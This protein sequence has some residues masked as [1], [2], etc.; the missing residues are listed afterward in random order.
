MLRPSL[1]GRSIPGF[2]SSMAWSF[3]EERQDERYPWPQGME[4][5]DG[6]WVYEAPDGRLFGVG[7]VGRG[8]RAAPVLDDVPPRKRRRLQAPGGSLH[9]DRR[10]SRRHAQACPGSSRP[11][12]PGAGSGLIGS[13]SWGGIASGDH[14][15]AVLGAQA[16]DGPRI[17]EPAGV[18]NHLPL[19]DEEHH[20]H[21]AYSMPVCTSEHSCLPWARLM[22]I[23]SRRTAGDAPA[24]ICARTAASDTAI[25][26][27]PGGRAGEP[28]GPQ[29]VTRANGRSTAP[30][31]F[32]IAPEPLAL[33][34][35]LTANQRR[36]TIVANTRGRARA[37][38]PSR[39]PG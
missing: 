27:E 8:A 28:R 38:R 10:R 5:H 3:R 25:R 2:G 17:G 35:P 18:G 36:E 12:R 31:S 21:T 29:P 1:P 26:A 32:T 13:S 33:L 39:A 34:I 23:A 9:S 22:R 11:P 14:L 15:D 7:R 30:R 4:H 19:A 16:G 6:F 20:G 24:A 37:R